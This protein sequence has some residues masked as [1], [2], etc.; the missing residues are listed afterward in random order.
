MSLSGEPF[1]TDV[2]NNF[3]KACEYDDFLERRGLD[4]WGIIEILLDIMDE[5]EQELKK[6][7]VKK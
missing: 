4:E 2:R 7:K 6:G 3:I 5:M 1:D